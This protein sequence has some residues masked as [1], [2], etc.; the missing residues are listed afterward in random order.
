MKDGLNDLYT[1]DKMERNAVDYE[2]SGIGSGHYNRQFI[3]QESFNESVIYYM[4]VV[5]LTLIWIGLAILSLKELDLRIRGNSVVASNSPAYNS[6]TVTLDGHQYTYNTIL[7]FTNE[8]E[9]T[10]YYYGNNPASGQVLTPVYVHVFG[11]GL[12]LGLIALFIRKIYKNMH[13]THHSDGAVN[14]HRFDE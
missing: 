11:H 9:V 2:G 12:L 4:L 7:A 10:V 5:I 14:Q 6:A 8:K 1:R 3:R 13:E